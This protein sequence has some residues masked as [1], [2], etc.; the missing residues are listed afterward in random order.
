MRLSNVV[1]HTPSQFLI[2]L[3]HAKV[4]VKDKGIFKASMFL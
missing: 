1:I 4:F 3:G 2:I